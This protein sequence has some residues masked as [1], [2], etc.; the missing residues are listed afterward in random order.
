MAY[1]LLTLLLTV[2]SS[3][4]LLIWLIHLHDSQCSLRSRCQDR[5]KCS[6]IWEIPVREIERSL[7]NSI[8]REFISKFLIIEVS[9][10]HEV[11]LPYHLFYTEA[12]SGPGLSASKRRVSKQSTEGTWSHVCM[13]PAAI[14]ENPL[15]GCIQLLFNNFCSMAN[16]PSFC[17]EN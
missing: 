14:W 2:S 16:S 8:T 3:T 1:N 13:L 4:A 6:K 9:Y 15:L 12:F 11:L 17:S 5:I 10:L 7:F